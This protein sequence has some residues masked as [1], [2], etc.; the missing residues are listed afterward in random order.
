MYWM[1]L[2]HTPRGEMDVS[3]F[4]YLSTYLPT[5]LLNREIY[6]NAAPTPRTVLST[7]FSG[8]PLEKRDGG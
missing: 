2:P 7:F 1:Y 8:K 6:C 4:N 3:S 5:Y